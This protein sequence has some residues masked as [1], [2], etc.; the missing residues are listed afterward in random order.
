MTVPKQVAWVTGASSGIGWASAIA[1]AREGFQVAASARS[2]E[3]L[4]ELEQR[5]EGI[6]AYP[7]DVA[8]P[9]A[10]DRVHAAIREEMG[11]VE[12]LVN[13][14]GYAVRGAMEEVP[15]HE[16]RDLF[17][18]N[19]YA[20]LALARLVLPGMRERRRGR[21][22]MVS[23][24]VGHVTFPFNGVYSA[25]KQAL[26]AVADSFRM[27]LA[28][29]GVEVSLVE[30]GPIRTRFG[31]VAKDKS[32]TRLLDGGSPYSSYYRKYLDG[33]F[34]ASTYWPASTVARAVVQAATDDVPKA[35]Y[36]VHWIAHF[37]PVLDMILPVRW[38]DWLQGRALG[39]TRR[40]V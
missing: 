22:V 21:I 34:P 17:D 37:L 7:L 30:P 19:L 24:V 15:L 4:R 27:E 11:E 3:A 18:V 38:V 5:H 29:W 31:K 8:D 32:V 40:A 1:L 23:S 33:V 39:L 9:D 26:D 35:R 6:R 25:S 10:R 14:A 13:N 2:Q 20:P 36:P 16:I 12:V 28:P